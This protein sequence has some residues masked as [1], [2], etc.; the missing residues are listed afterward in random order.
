MQQFKDAYS[1]YLKVQSITF[2][3]LNSQAKKMR[4][5]IKNSFNAKNKVNNKLK[6]KN[7]LFCM[8]INKEVQLSKSLTRIG[9]KSKYKMI[10][11]V[12]DYNKM[13]K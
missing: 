6:K 7:K 9:D 10:M 8:M 2:R 1:A 4:I 13:N 11:Q 3:H 5:S 12:Q